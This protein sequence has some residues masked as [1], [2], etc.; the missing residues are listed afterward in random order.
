MLLIPVPTRRGQAAARLPLMGLFH[1]TTRQMSCTS[2][3][4]KNEIGQDVMRRHSGRISSL[5]MK[6]RIWAEIPDLLFSSKPKNLR[7]DA[8]MGH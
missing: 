2:D 5:K 7:H 8:I 6:T 3:S 1:P 4:L